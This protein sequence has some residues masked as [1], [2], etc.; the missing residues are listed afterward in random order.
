MRPNAPRIDPT[1]LGPVREFRACPIGLHSPALEAV[2]NILRTG[3]MGG[4]YCIICLEPHRKWA[5]ARLSGIRGMPPV[6]VP[7]VE[8]DD[9]V[10][11]EW[12]IFRRRWEAETGTRLP[13]EFDGP[14][15]PGPAPRNTGGEAR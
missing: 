1:D 14:A 9:L 5:L 10:E 8:Y 6:P 7:G 4:K 2:L 13:A 15:S 3:T 12:D 11:A